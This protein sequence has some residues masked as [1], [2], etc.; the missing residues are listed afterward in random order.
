MSGSHNAPEPGR[1]GRY[2][3]EDTMHDLPV[4]PPAPQQPQPADSGDYTYTPPSSAEWVRASSG[5]QDCTVWTERIEA[6]ARE[7][8]ARL[9]A[10][11]NVLDALTVGD[12]TRSLPLAAAAAAYLEAVS[13]TCDGKQE[14]RYA[15]AALNVAHV[16]HHA[17]FQATVAAQNERQT[18]ALEALALALRARG[19]DGR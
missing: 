9:R 2:S 12:D 3:L 5:V 15:E 6:R 13:Q 19:D 10:L 11:E 8:D 14:L 16:I 17:E 18:A 4:T 1:D 7:H